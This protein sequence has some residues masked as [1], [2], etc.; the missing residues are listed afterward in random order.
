MKERFHIL[1]DPDV[2]ADCRRAADLEALPL[3]AYLRRIV[4]L[5][6][7]ERLRNGTPAPPVDREVTGGV[8]G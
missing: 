5:A 3:Q 4:I 1:L 6:N 2:L 8:G 7:R